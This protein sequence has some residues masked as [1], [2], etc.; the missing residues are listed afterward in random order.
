MTIVN[1]SGGAIY[2]TNLLDKR[3]EKIVGV[4]GASHQA[5]HVLAV[6]GALLYTRG[7]MRAYSQHDT[8]DKGRL[9]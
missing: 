4:S 6:G 8:L 2:A 9:L 7:L 1:G 3:M 5:M